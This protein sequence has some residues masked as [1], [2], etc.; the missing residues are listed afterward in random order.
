M[1]LH[2]EVGFVEVLFVGDDMVGVFGLTVLRTRNGKRR[3]VD[4]LV[5]GVGDLLLVD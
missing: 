2:V 1:T 5:V 3:R 4:L